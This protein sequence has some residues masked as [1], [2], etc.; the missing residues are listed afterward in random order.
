M[1]NE[2]SICQQGAVGESCVQQPCSESADQS[3]SVP[4]TSQ[5]SIR[6][7]P[8]EHAKLRAEAAQHNTDVSSFVR[9]MLFPVIGREYFECSGCKKLVGNEYLFCDAIDFLICQDCASKVPKD[10]VSSSHAKQLLLALYGSPDLVSRI[11][12]GFWILY[13]RR[14]SGELD[15]RISQVDS[16][17]YLMTESR[18]L[19]QKGFQP[20]EGYQN[21]KPLGLKVDVCIACEPMLPFL[22]ESLFS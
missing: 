15:V 13:Q 7:T 18:R 21:G 14:R 5:V 6:F 1:E 17:E 9:S 20:L 2:A 11:G 19:L 8:I 10:M 3:H 4:R 22:D 16:L 12:T